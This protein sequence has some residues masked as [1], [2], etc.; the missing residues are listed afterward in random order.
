[1][2]ISRYLYILATLKYLPPPFLVE[3]QIYCF[4]TIHIFN[5]IIVCYFCLNIVD[6]NQFIIKE[7]YKDGSKQIHC[8]SGHSDCWHQHAAKTHYRKWYHI[9]TC[10]ST[11]FWWAEYFVSTFWVICEYFFEYCVSI[12]WILCEYF[13]STLLSISSTKGKVH[14]LHN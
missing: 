9:W 12:F 6:V 5:G 8:F 13:M 4:I 3:V 2:L 1:M 10:D 14:H 7:I 11:L